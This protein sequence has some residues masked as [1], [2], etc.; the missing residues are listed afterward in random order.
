MEVPV[1][2]ILAPEHGLYGSSI[3]TTN[4]PLLFG[5]RS[6]VARHCGE[7]QASGLLTT[8]FFVNE[9]RFVGFAVTN[10]ADS[11]ANMAVLVQAVRENHDACDVP[12]AQLPKASGVNFASMVSDWEQHKNNTRVPIFSRHGLE[13][14]GDTSVEWLDEWLRLSPPAGG[15]RQW[16]DGRSAKEVARAWSLGNRALNQMPPGIGEIL[17]HVGFLPKVGIVE[18]RA[19]LDGF[20]GNARNH[21]MVLV[22][23]QSTSEQR[24]LVAIEAKADE[25]FGN[26]S[27]GE[28]KQKGLNKPRSK[29]PARIDRLVKAL[30]GGVSSVVNTLRYQLLHAVG[31]TIIEGRRFECA[32]VIFLV[33]EFRSQ[34]CSQANL[35]RNAEHYLQF[36]RALT[37]DETVELET[38]KLIGPHFVPGDDS[39]Q[40]S[41]HFLPG[42]IPIYFGNSVTVVRDQ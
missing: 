20:T 19:E 21:D 4:P 40:P 24:V 35:D 38:G 36:L 10:D 15:S 13:I 12:E 8:T 30:F 11:K 18:L 31:S 17:S 1:G 34:S 14:R 41:E 25:P 22:G 29:V 7:L 26:D 2:E 9:V 5:V 6:D 42:N 27:I 32:Q 16:Q 37:G 23:R 39:D 3:F 33:H 28:A